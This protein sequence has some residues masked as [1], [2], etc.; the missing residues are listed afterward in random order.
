MSR[1]APLLF[2]LAALACSA[3][4]SRSAPQARLATDLPAPFVDTALQI[5]GRA[6][7]PK[8]ERSPASSAAGDRFWDAAPCAALP[9]AGRGQVGPPPAGPSGRPPLF[10]D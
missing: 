4:G 9:P 10:R 8:V 3:T 5:V 1:A 7:G 6:G 2:A